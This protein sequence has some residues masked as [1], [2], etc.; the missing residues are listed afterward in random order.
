MAMV[1]AFLLGS[2]I[3]LGSAGLV[4]SAERVEAAG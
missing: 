4:V 2:R 1:M 3:G